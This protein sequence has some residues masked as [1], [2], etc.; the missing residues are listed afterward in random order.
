MLENDIGSTKGSETQ[1]RVVGCGNVY[2]TIVYRNKSKKI[3]DSVIVTPPRKEEC[4]GAMTAPLARVVT[5]ALRRVLDS[6]KELADL[7]RQLSNHRCEKYTVGC[8]LSCSQALADVLRDVEFV[9]PSCI[10]PSDTSSK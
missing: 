8:L 1:K 2:V 6:G 10:L 9:L 4:G 5:F 3:F 7:L